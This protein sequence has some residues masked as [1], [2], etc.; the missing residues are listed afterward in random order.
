MAALCREAQDQQRIVLPEILDLKVAL[1][2]AA[3][4]LARRGSNLNIDASMVRRLGA[5]CLQVLLSAVMTWKAD[6]ALLSIVD[7]SPEFIDGVERLGIA[8][9][10]LID[11]D[12]L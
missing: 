3:E 11:Q 7:P 6:E 2:L 5:Q 12:L 10:D 9:S 4:L 8:A 1:P